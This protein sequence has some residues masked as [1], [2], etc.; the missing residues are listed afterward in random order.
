MVGKDEG[1][2]RP[3]VVMG[4]LRWEFPSRKKKRGPVRYM[5][6]GTDAVTDLATGVSSGRGKE[7]V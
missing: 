3:E 1:P 2:G 4:S 7:E 5:R 6:T